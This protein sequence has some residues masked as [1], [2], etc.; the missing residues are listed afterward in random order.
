MVSLATD[1]DGGDEYTAEMV[2]VFRAV[3]TVSQRAGSGKLSAGHRNEM[4]I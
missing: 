1:K 4:N 3:V 2:T